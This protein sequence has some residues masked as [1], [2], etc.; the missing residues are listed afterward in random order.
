MQEHRAILAWL[1]EDGL[2]N[3]YSSYCQM[4]CVRFSNMREGFCRTENVVDHGLVVGALLSSLAE[5]TR[6]GNDT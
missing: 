5:S 4:C 2:G 3:G 6:L 1:G